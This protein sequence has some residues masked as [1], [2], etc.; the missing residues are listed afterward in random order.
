MATDRSLYGAHK[1]LETNIKIKKEL[2]RIYSNFPGYGEGNT[3]IVSSQDN[4]IE[5]Y[6]KND[7]IVPEYCPTSS[8]FEADPGMHPFVKYM[9]GVIEAQ[10]THDL[11]DIRSMIAAKNLASMFKR[12]SHN[13]YSERDYS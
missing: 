12:F 10:K 1:Q 13:I 6:K 11:A 3:L 7:V 2:S 5:N 9:R 4:L 8:L